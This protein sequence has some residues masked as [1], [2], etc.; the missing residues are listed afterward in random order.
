MIPSIRVSSCTLFL[1]SIASAGLMTLKSM[2]NCIDAERLCPSL[3]DPAA[4]ESIRWGANAGER[5]VPIYAED[6]EKNL[7]AINDWSYV[8]RRFAEI[9][10]QNVQYD[11]KDG[12][13]HERF[14]FR[15]ALL[16]NKVLGKIVQSMGNLDM[17]VSASSNFGCYCGL[18]RFLNM[19]LCHHLVQRDLV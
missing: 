5:T 10:L 7:V 16:R 14:R 9:G 11:N 19:W 15:Q 12:P 1:S 2:A 17:M 18:E 8:W 6:L 4:D 3:C 13:A